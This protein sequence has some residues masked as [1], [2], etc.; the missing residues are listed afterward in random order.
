MQILF[1][2]VIATCEVV[3]SALDWP[4]Y[5]GEPVMTNV[6]SGFTR[7]LIIFGRQMLL[8]TYFVP[9]TV[10]ISVEIIRVVQC[11]FL[12]QDEDLVWEGE[13]S[14]AVLRTHCITHPLVY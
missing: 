13:G 1:S 2:A 8:L 7:W 10:V 9:I 6:G 5:L 4:Y 12:G 11:W 14:K 3:A